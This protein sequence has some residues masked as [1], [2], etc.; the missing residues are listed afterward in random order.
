MGSFKDNELSRR[1]FLKR[2]A[3]LGAAGVV[4]SSF[5]SPLFGAFAQDASGVINLR[6]QPSWIPDVQVGGVYAAIYEGYYARQKLNVNMMPGGPGILGGAVIDSGGAELGEM[7]SSVDLV[8][9]VSQGMKLKSFATVF[10]RSPAGL[11][12]ITEY[13]DGKKGAD[14]SAGP[15]ALK[16]KRV[17]ITGGVNL[18]WRVMCAKAGLDPERDFQIVS[19][20]FDLSPLLDGTVQAIWCF[21]TNQPGTVRDRGYKIGTI[22]SYE[23]GYKVPGNF[24]LA[25]SSYLADKA[26]H[27]K[28]FLGATRDGW[29]FTNSARGMD[30][31]CDKITQTLAPKYGTKLQQQ[32]NQCKDQIPFM[33]SALTGKKG[34]L[35]SNLEDW[36]SAIKI[37]ADIGEIEKVP[38]V[39]DVV[40]TAILDMI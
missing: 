11:A 28:R 5:A 27:A 14:Y 36:E 8:K 38:K 7:S 18:P 13:P 32:I 3:M 30:S 25:K 26:D 20:G 1:D 40:T 35:Y 34:L 6:F 16:G 23:W 19:T 31:V 15:A 9:A 33:E 12:Y 10:Q 21:L 24:Y 22:D 29:G 4:G 37:M 39:G 2:S 17:G